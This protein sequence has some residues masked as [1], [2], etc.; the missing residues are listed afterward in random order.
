MKEIFKQLLIAHKTS[1]VTNVLMKLGKSKMRW[2][3]VGG[4]KN[5]LATINIGT[6]P[7]AGVTERITNAIDAVLEKEWKLQKEPLDIRTP[8]KASELWFNIEEGKIS[9]IKDPY[10]KR[11]K[12]L[13][14]KINVT[15]YDSGK[16]SKPTVEIRDK[17]IG[18]EPEQFSKTILD[19]NGNNKIGKLHLMGAY[20][21]GGS[22][23]LSYNDL[24]I[25]MS[26]P[27]FGDNRKKKNVAWTV[28][29]INA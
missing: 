15:L 29:R 7:A 16:D 4:R 13:S 12:D 18:L 3:P 14:D 6:D 24:T 20:G 5:N 21:Q 2:E 10:D 23:A 19:L 1:E 17:G 28:V 11:L 8:R 26:K 22:T 9:K 27:F 25:I